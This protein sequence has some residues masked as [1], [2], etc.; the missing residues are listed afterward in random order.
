MGAQ[1]TPDGAP[2]EGRT[3]RQGGAAGP[4]RIPTFPQ[5]RRKLASP[6]VI[7][8]GKAVFQV[9]CTACHGKDLRGGDM[10][11][12]SLL[13]SLVALSDQ[14]GEAIGP[15]VHGSRQ[16]KGMPAFNLTEEDTTA[17][18]EYIHSVLAQVGNQGRPPGA[19]QIPELKVIVGDPAAG[20]AYFQAHCASCHSAT[21]DMAG[22]ATRF[23]D[24]RNLQNTWVSG[25]KS[26]GGGF[27]GG[28]GDTA[29]EGSTVKVTFPD[30][31]SVDGSLLSENE[32]VVALKLP[33]GTRQSY[34]RDNGIPKV[35]VHQPN[36]P[37]KKLAATLNDQ[38]MHN[39][40]AYLAT[41]K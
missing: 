22:I 32:F 4:A 9:N 14:H 16:D 29:N 8:R 30:G 2:A 7:A 26:R 23:S 41:L 25:V 28:F 17:V 5:Q 37:H 20:Q 13:R 34:A 27:G 18:A 10:G 6:E 40:T 38:D 33:D 35:E 12:P 21:G 24:P 36:D 3:A 1:E 11:G 39:V 31:K 15:I 19:E